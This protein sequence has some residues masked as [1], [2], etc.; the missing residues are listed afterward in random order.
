LEKTA[1][2]KVLAFRLKFI[3][4]KP[5]RSPCSRFGSKLSASLPGSAY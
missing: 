3:Q 1:F 2:D 4:R 5:V